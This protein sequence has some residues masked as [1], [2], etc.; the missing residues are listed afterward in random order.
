MVEPQA[1]LDVYDRDP[2]LTANLQTL[3]L[4]LGAMIASGQTPVLMID[5][6]DTINRHYGANLEPTVSECFTQLFATQTTFGLNTGAPIEWAGLRVL[7]RLQPGVICPLNIL[8]GGRKA[9]AWA[10]ALQGYVE[11]PIAA[12]NKGAAIR[13]L[14]EYLE[15]VVPDVD[16]R[17]VFVS[18]FPGAEQPQQPG[19]DDSV[20]SEAGERLSIVVDVGRGRVGRDVKPPRDVLCV[21]PG[22]VEQRTAPIGFKATVEY[23]KCVT[24]TLEKPVLAQRAG[25]LRAKLGSVLA[26]QLAEP[27]LS[28]IKKVSLMQMAVDRR[29]RLR[30]DQALTVIVDAPGMLH[31][32]KRAEGDAWS[33]IYDIPFRDNASGQWEAQVPADANAFKVFRYDAD[34]NGGHWEPGPNYS[35]MRR[36]S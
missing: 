22:E 10:P 21:G 36:G 29:I 3:S 19:I 33:R 26:K 17:F 2:I 4:R 5:V 8:S 6:D 15:Q 18:D 25:V 11:L 35:V 23:L 34:L 12:S 31:A 16:A 13:R 9:H 30:S 32:G 24:R 27:S 14:G 7:S 20:L 1:P 28:S